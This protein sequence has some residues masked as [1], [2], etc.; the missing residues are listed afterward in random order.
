MMRSNNED[1]GNVGNCAVVV[2]GIVDKSETYPSEGGKSFDFPPSVNPVIS[3][4]QVLG[5]IRLDK[6]SDSLFCCER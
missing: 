5:S 4:R 6:K 2:Q 1:W 3:T